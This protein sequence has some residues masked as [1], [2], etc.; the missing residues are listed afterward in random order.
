MTKINKQS[1]FGWGTDAYPAQ[2]P[3]ESGY[4]SERQE[5]SQMPAINQTFKWVVS[6]KEILVV[7]PDKI[8]NA[9]SAL[10]I[11][12]N[13]HGPYATGSV[14]I[15]HRWTTSFVVEESNVDLDFLYGLFK[16]WAKYPSINF[17]D[18]NHPLSVDTVKDKNGIPLPMNINKKSSDPGA[19]EHYVDKLW[20]NTDSEDIFTQDIQRNYPGQGDMAATGERLTDDVYGCDRCDEVFDS[21]PEYLMHASHDH[22]KSEPTGYEEEIRDNDES[23][24]PDNEASR[25]GGDLGIH[26]GAVDNSPVGPIPFSYNVEEDRIY[27]GEPGEE[28]IKLDSANPFGLAE[29]YYTPEGDLLITSQANI[30]YTVRHLMNIWSHMYPEYEIKHVYILDVN[31]GKKIREKVANNA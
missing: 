2:E 30:P 28:G 15:S 27:V 10:G 16:R 3:Q 19:G 9:Y 5:M 18:W 6:G 26:T 22:P 13:H 21:Y 1:D 8:D 17:T 24:Y 20:V 12:T 31:D 11:K 14:D 7:D 23:F 25:P 4:Q 29:G